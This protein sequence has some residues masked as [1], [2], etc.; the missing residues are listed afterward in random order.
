MG[1]ESEGVVVTFSL[2]VFPC[3]GFYLLTYDDDDD[4]CEVLHSEN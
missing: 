2:D 4:D 1:E 3:A